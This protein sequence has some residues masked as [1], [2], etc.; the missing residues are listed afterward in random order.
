MN[1]TQ[2]VFGFVI[3]AA[4]CVALMAGANVLAAGEVLT[5]S[6]ITI[7]GGQATVNGIEARSAVGQPLAGIEISS[8]G[9]VCVGL[10]CPGSGSS[11]DVPATPSATPGGSSTP[12]S[13][14]TPTASLTPD[15]SSTPEPSAT[16]TG[17]LTPQITPTASTTPATG[18]TNPRIFLPLVAR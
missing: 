15:E 3:L 10:L 8:A 7:A 5:R 4:L 16:P 2:K 18:D 14:S 12:G 1:T 13:S 6:A 9:D 11:Q 17:T